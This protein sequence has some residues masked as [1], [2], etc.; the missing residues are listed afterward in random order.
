[1]VILPRTRLVLYA[2]LNLAVC[3]PPSH[4]ELASLPQSARD[5][6]LTAALPRA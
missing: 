3:G 6:S 2:Q 4:M 1:M 5:T